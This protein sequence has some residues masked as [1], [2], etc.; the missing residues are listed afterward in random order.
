MTDR[1]IKHYRR[2]Q[3]DRTLGELKGKLPVRP[4]TGWI[5]E[6]RSL[7]L[8][9]TA[10][11]ARRIGVAQS[12]ASNFEKSERERTITLQSLDKIADALEC[13]LHYCFVPR[14]GL[15]AELYER[16]ETLYRHNEKRVEQHMRL[17]GQGSSA[18]DDARK[19]LEILKLYRQVWKQQ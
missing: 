14:K 10:E 19:A 6:I 7:L 17:E 18:A 13:D 5:A 1:D 4:K 8:M 11:L 12:V 9:T 16:A 15:E 3:V 2:S